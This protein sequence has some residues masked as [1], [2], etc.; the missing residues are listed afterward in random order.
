[1]VNDV[2]MVTH[3]ETAS[4]LQGQRGTQQ[5][6]SGNI[7]SYSLPRLSRALTRP[8]YS[9]NCFSMSKVGWVGGREGDQKICGDPDRQ[10]DG[11]NQSQDKGD[12]GRCKPG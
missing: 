6:R 1:M 8:P 9:S 3:R 10:D 12:L 5:L 7:V 2:R 4:Y 11:S